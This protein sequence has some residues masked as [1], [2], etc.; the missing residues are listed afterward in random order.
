MEYAT[1]AIICWIIATILVAIVGKKAFF[2]IF[3][4]PKNKV[5]K[6]EL[7]AYLICS[8]LIGAVISIGITY[9]IIFI[10]SA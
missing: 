7:R 9:F 5:L 8:A 3:G 10:H 2:R 6:V 1:F 4:M